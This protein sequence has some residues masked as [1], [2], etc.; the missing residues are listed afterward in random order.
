MFTA[1]VRPI[2]RPTPINP[3]AAIRPGLA[4]SAHP[5]PTAVVTPLGGGAGAGGAGVGGVGGSGGSGLNP[6][7]G[8]KRPAIKMLGLNE[9]VAASESE[10]AKEAE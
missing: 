7:F 10:Q 3:A 1:T 4:S 2:G 6:T 8:L 9:V 5:T